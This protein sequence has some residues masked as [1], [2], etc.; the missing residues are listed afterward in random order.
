MTVPD[1]RHP[2]TAFSEDASMPLRRQRCFSARHQHRCCAADISPMFQQAVGPH[3]TVDA[4]A[5]DCP[6]LML[7]TVTRHASP[8]SPN[9]LFKC[10]PA[11]PAQLVCSSMPIAAPRSAPSLAPYEPS[12]NNVFH[13]LLHE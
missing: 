7:P 10:R 9:G 11:R 6:L 3:T 2:G 13:I 8:A 12:T 1:A 5:I 4:S